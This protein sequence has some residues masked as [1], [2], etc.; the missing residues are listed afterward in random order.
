MSTIVITGG[1]HNS[2]LAVAQ[3]LLKKKHK[4]VWIGHRHSSRGDKSDSAEY[5]EVTGSGIKFHDLV[6]GRMVLDP[7]EIIRF[8]IGVYKAGAL[9][10]KIKPDTVLSFGGYLG[11]AVAIAAKMLGIPI[12]L[13]EQTVTAGRANK[14]IGKLANKIYLTWPESRSYFPKHKTKVIG[15]PLRK[16]IL[17]SAKKDF[18]T[19]NKPT[20]LI[21]GGKQG[22]HMLN[23]FIFSNI[24]D[25]LS[26]F[27]LIHQTGTSSVTK[28]YETSIKLKHRLGSLSDCYQ[29]IGYIG[30]HEIGQYLHSA[31]YYFGRSGAH[32]C[33][34]LGVVGLKS[35]LLPL[36]STHDHEQYKNARILEKAKIGVILPEASP[37]FPQFLS[38]YKQLQNLKPTQIKLESNA[39]ELL[40]QDF[41]SDLQK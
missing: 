11:G 2:A 23:Q 9:L 20:L 21:M 26:H 17:E 33:Y 8:P 37:T 24:H 27:N 38:A 16:G 40:V 39:T 30:E 1:H 32:I 34:E 25:L 13:H 15:L 4:V 19:R 5:R 28:D 35:I 29:P 10:K 14:F 3:L 31:Q 18:F 22:A 12:Y 6:A 7:K 41:V 36:M